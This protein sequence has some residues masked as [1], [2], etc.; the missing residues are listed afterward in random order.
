[1]HSS[2]RNSY[3][4]YV[5]QS[6]PTGRT[7][8]G[9]LDIP[10]GMK[11]PAGTLDVLIRWGSRKPMPSAR[12]ELNSVSAIATASD[13][14]RAFQHMQEAGIRIVPVSLSPDPLKAMERF[15]PGGVVMG[16]K[17]SGF[18]GKDIAI[19]ERWGMDEYG[20]KKFD[21]S[22]YRGFDF[23][24]YYIRPTRE[25]RIHVVG[26]KVVRIQGKYCDFPEQKKTPYVRNY[27]N[28]YRFRAPK[29]D[30]RSDRKKQAIDAV[31][32]CGLDFGA[33]DMLMDEAG[34]TYVLEVNTAPA[35]SPLTARCYAGALALLVEARSDGIVLAE[36]LLHTELPGYGEE[37]DDG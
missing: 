36:S 29:H 30:L 17:R 18:G 12:L 24:S 28:G 13:K 31:K 5:R 27:T 10:F 15:A 37:E 8:A 14:V 26:D 23:F 34:Y 22:E 19:F 35:C 25:Y 16:R 9:I 32:A 4:T 21:T 20:R 33:V 7:I 3:L 11:A 2:A 6:R 1:M